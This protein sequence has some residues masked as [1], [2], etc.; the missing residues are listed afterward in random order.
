VPNFKESSSGLLVPE[1]SLTQIGRDEHV[2]IDGMTGTGKTWIA[3]KLHAF[4][5][6]VVVHDTKGTFEWPE[7]PKDQL[8]MVRTL[9]ALSRVNPKR[10]SKVIYRPHLEELNQDAYALFYRWAYLSGH[11]RVITDELME[12]CDNPFKYA[13]YLKGIWTR[14]RELGITSTSCTQRPTGVPVL[15]MSEATHTFSLNLRMPQDR[16]KMAEVTGCPELLRQPGKYQAWYYR[17]GAETAIRVRFTEQGRG[18]G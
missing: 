1:Y 5:P 3:R 6:Y 16:Q 17:Q 2:F 7:V 14:G 8:I 9:K 12:V 15:A 18:R 13:L 10:H 11:W 4:D